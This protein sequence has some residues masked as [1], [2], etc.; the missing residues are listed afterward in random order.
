MGKY[1]VVFSQKKSQYY[2]G[3]AVDYM[4]TEI[5]G[6]KMCAEAYMPGAPRNY[7]YKAL[8]IDFLKLAQKYGYD[9]WMFDFEEDGKY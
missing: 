2:N 8:K 4:Q 5:D 6:K 7:I 3:E 9:E 1:R